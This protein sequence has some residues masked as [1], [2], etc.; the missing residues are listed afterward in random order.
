MKSFGLQ[1]VNH[2]YVTYMRDRI[3]KRGKNEV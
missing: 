2:D 1:D 3:N